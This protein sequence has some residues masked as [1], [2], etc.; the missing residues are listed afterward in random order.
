MEC[1]FAQTGFLFENG[2]R[3][4]PCQS[5]Y[6][7]QCFRV[8]SPFRSRRHGQ[9]GLS[10][11][12]IKCWG[13]FICE[14][15]TVRA[16][17][18]RELHGTS[19]WRLLCFERIRVLDLVHYWS[20]GTHKQYQSKL[21]TIHQFELDFGVPILQRTPLSAPPVSPT[22]PLMWAQEAYSLRLS[23]GRVDIS[24]SP[25]FVQFSTVRQLRSAA[26]QF[27][28]WD[29]MISRPGASVLDENKRILH[30]SCRPTDDLSSSLFATGL[31]TRL[32]EESAPSMALLDR[33]V[34]FLES[35]LDCRF[36][37]ARTPDALREFSLAG[38]ANLL[39]WLAWVRSTEGFSLSWSDITVVAPQDGATLDLMDNVGAVLLT[40]LPETKSSRSRRADIVVAYTTF[41]GFSLGRWVTRARVHAYAGQGSKVFTH[42]PGGA[43]WTSRY[44]RE[45]YLYP[46]LRTQQ[47]AG[48]PLLKAFDSLTGPNSIAAK[49][50]S[51]H[52]YRRGARTQVTRGGSVGNQVTAYHFRKASSEQVYEHGRWQRKRSG[53]KIDVVYREW[54][55]LDRVKISLYCQ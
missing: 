40:L 30:L 52:C 13:H 35:D 11:P 54:T 15:C 46:S 10:F 38:L 32:G 24:G 18:G 42:S 33:H 34:R 47:A 41:S 44:F 1:T 28:S 20:V 39:F 48:D 14:A 4:R 43:Q 6:H 53:E 8:G 27:F 9:E 25:L 5:A 26:S 3:A 21:M 2:R 37:A 51:L 17:L 45:R 12:T 7:T 50:W 16:V 31:G 29:T 36:L 23:S 22:I 49:F 55:I 19:D